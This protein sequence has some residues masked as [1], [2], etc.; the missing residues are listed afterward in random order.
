MPI[1]TDGAVR[2]IGARRLSEEEP[3]KLRKG[4]GR[5]QG[6]RNKTTV[7][8]EQTLMAAMKAASES[9]S[10]SQIDAMSPREVMLFAMRLSAKAGFWHRAAELAATV[11]PYVHSKLQS[12]NIPEETPETTADAA[13]L[14][15][16]LN[17]LI[18]KQRAAAQAAALEARM[19]QEL[20]SMGG[21]S[22][23][24][25]GGSSGKAPH[26]VM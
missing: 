25:F 1:G 12:M 10:P 2:V 11:A 22:S 3:R 20:P 5:P 16:Q 4:P 21:G 24:S 13:E 9:M 17:D 8:R 26:S 7:L 15:E 6:S 14:N 19:S 23:F 18:N